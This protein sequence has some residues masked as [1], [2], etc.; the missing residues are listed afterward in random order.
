MTKDRDLREIYRLIRDKLISIQIEHRF[1]NALDYCRRQT[2]KGKGDQFFFQILCSTIFDSGLRS[3]VVNQRSDVIRRVFKGFDILKVSKIS[4]TDHSLKTLKDKTGISRSRLKACIL[5]ANRML[6]L[7]LIEYGS[8]QRYLNSFPTVDDLVKD[9][10]EFKWI[11]ET[12]AY[13]FLKY[14]GFDVM[15]PDRDV[16]RLLFR[17]GLIDKDE[18]TK[19]IRAQIQRVGRRMAEAVGEK[20]SVVDEV[21]WDYCSGGINYVKYPICTAKP[22]CEEC[23][24]T[25]FCVYFHKGAT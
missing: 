11:G 22:K 14:I 19:E 24:L 8:F 20:V 21:L 12:N 16:R 6:L 9:L 2:F 23:V 1:T 5:N 13:G 7:T 3:S 4:T 10:T 17:L 15:K 18:D 25:Q